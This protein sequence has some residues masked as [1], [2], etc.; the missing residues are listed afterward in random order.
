MSA[1]RYNACLSPVYNRG[2]PTPAFLDELIDWA[3]LAPDEIFAPNAAPVDIFT[4]IKSSLGALKGKDGAGTP[5]YRWDSLL[6]RKAALCEAMRV[7]AGMESSWNWKEGVDRTNK[8]SMKNIAGQ[9]T[10]VF[11]VSFDSIRLGNFAM[12]NFAIV[13]GID[14]AEAFILAM[15]TDHKLALEYYARLVR[16]SIRWAGPLLRHGE[17]SVYPWMRRAAVAEFMEFLK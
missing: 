10:G 4:V 15:K 2:R 13:H 6:H 1:R 9:E 17:D 11:Q 7:H 14:H 3:R 16:V 8:R 12:R 5:I